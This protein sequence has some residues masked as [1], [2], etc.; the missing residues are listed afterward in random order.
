M[1]DKIKITEPSGGQHIAIAGD[2]NSILASK[3]DT[4]GTCV[5]ETKVFPNGG[6]FLIFKPVNMRDFMF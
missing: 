4:E 1:R 6:P 5:V 3:K 2:I